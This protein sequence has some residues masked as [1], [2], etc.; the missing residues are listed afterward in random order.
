MVVLLTFAVGF[1]HGPPAAVT[2]VA[3]ADGAGPSHV[4]LTEGL[5]VRDGDG[6][7]YV[8]PASWG[9]SPLSPDAAGL[10]SAEVFVPG[11]GGL[12]V[13]DPFGLVEPTGGGPAVSSLLGLGRDSDQIVA[14]AI[15]ATTARA[16]WDVAAG[17]V[18]RWTGEDPL[19]GIAPWDGELHLV[20][21]EDGVL[22][23]LVLDAAGA[24]LSRAELGPADSTNPVLRAT[25][26]ALWLVERSTD[27][28]QLATFPDR[29]AVGPTVAEVLGP[30]EVDD[31]TWVAL[32]GVLHEVVGASV[33][34]GPDLRTLDCL[35][36]IDG[37]AWA[38]SDGL[39]HAL[40]ADGTLDAP[41]VGPADVGAPDLDLVAE[42]AVALCFSQWRVWA[43]DA[44]VDPG[45]AP[46]GDASEPPP[47]LLAD[48]GCGCD[49]EGGVSLGAFLA[50]WFFRRRRCPASLPSCSPSS[51]LPPTRKASACSR[52][53]P[54]RSTRRPAAG[55]AA[56]RTTSA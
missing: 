10:S 8:C 37:V 2:G 9:S 34:P 1:A 20:G 16:V 29:I 45:P 18:V 6:W 36:A 12:F 4:A 13:A 15:G 39:L 54:T 19:T 49:S 46:G 27:I 26:S 25:P 22:H 38:C 23:H 30:V 3:A 48:G 31:H 28:Q 53:C 5:A 43:G 21:P 40:F 17:G 50:P 51:S 35:E 44:G 7:R 52:R 33:V 56:T 41:I 42:T 24:E 14:L 47:L 11:A 55:T 32:D